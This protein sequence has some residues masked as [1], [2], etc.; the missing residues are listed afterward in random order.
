MNDPKSEGDDN[1][2]Q[3]EKAISYKKIWL[4][5]SQLILIPCY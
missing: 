5:H 2:I 4:R 3:F 1:E